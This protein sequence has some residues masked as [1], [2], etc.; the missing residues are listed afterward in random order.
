VTDN[1]GVARQPNLKLRYQRQLRGWSIDD[2]ADELC[3]LAGLLDEPAP[4]VNGNMVSRWE[5]GVR[6]PRPRYIRLLCR[7]FE[8]PADQLGLV[9]AEVE[10][11]PD[12]D[13]EPSDDWYYQVLVCELLGMPA[14]AAGLVQAGAA[15]RMKRRDFIAYGVGLAGASGIDL[16]G[17][18]AVLNRLNMLDAPRLGDLR[19]LVTKLEQ[20]YDTTSPRL[21]LPVVRGNLARVRAVAAPPS[22]RLTRDLRSLT[23]ELSV[24]AGRLAQRLHN[25]GDAESF[26][27]QAAQLANA[28]GDD[29]LRAFAIASRSALYSNIGDGGTSTLAVALLDHAETVAG[30]ASS[31]YQRAWTLAHR[32]EEYAALKNDT[33]S[34]RDQEAAARAVATAQNKGEGFF[35]NWSERR[36]E[37][38][39]GCC[40]VE[41]GDWTTAVDILERTAARTSPAMLSQR[42]AVL[43]DLATAYVGQGE[44]DQGCELLM[45]TL[46]IASQTGLAEIVRRIGV[47]RR[48][49]GTA[50]TPAVRRFD[51]QLRSIVLG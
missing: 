3:K 38:Y 22:E 33:A 2:V 6:S 51:E 20:D 42:S 10:D 18:A 32:S 46:E 7:L 9:K 17:L 43:I 31:P 21:L 30:P 15:D 45:T 23:G 37:G 28:S 48:D 24:L 29:Q 14:E 34:Q 27:Q 5:R 12:R 25:L 13:D 16:E 26:Y 50:D 19:V 36:L 8:L 35:V 11:D 39:R 44:I 41:L 49:L 47:R 1:G 40:A 4:G